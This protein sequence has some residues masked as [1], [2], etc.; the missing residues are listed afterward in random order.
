MHVSSSCC[1]LITYL[2]LQF[3][4]HPQ[5][6]CLNLKNGEESPSSAILDVAVRS[7]ISGSTANFKQR[8][9]WLVF[10]FGRT[11]V[12]TYLLQKKKNVLHIALAC[13]PCSKATKTTWRLVFAVVQ[14]VM[15]W[16]SPEMKCC[17]VSDALKRKK[18]L[19]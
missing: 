8:V 13:C 17:L 18:L 19:K 11:C 2:K 4:T 12:V 14:K 1:Y 7:L 5:N 15:P 3:C 9:T 10:F 6:Q 16:Q